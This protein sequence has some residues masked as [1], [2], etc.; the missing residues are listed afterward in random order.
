MRVDGIIFA[1]DDADRADQEGPG[2]RAGRER[3]DVARHPEGQPGHAR[4]PLGLRLL[5]RRRGRHRPGGRGRDLAGRASATT[6]T[7][8]S[9][10]CAPTWSGATSKDRIRPLVDQLFRD[11][12]TGVGQSGRYLFDKPKLTRLMERRVGVRGRTRVTGPSATC[13]SPR[14]AGR[15]DGADPARVSDRAITRGYDQCGTLGSGNHFLEVQVVD[16]VHDPAA[17]EVMGL[18]EGPDHRADPL[19]LAR[20]GLPGLRR[21][22]G[23]V[24]ERPEAV[25]LRAA[26]LAA[27]LCAGAESG[28][29]G[30]PG[31]DARGGQLSP[32]ATASS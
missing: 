25:R 2:A 18:H 23:D 22:P 9:G 15:L 1:D 7:A 5:H 10:C 6:S 19:R 31:R 30:V 29:P 16:R 28:G 8:A 12:P 17:A 14:P 3:G 20:A 26:R 27:R 4:H 11:I 13:W 24:Q 21:L 32:G